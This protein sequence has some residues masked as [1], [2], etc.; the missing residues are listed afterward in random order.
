MWI[1][2]SLRKKGIESTFLCERSSSMDIG[3]QMALALSVVKKKKDH[4]EEGEMAALNL[5]I[6]RT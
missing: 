2:I 1:E 3:W 5:A 6:T 4:K